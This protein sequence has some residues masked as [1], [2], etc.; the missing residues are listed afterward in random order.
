MALIRSGIARNL[1][2]QRLVRRLNLVPSG[3]TGTATEPITGEELKIYGEIT[4]AITVADGNGDERTF[5]VSFLA[6]KI[7][8]DM[9]FGFE[10]LQLANP[11]IDFQDNKFCWRG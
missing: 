8:E 4:L 7:E 3:P 10:W 1:I 5:D 6:T 11:D 2:N 9:I